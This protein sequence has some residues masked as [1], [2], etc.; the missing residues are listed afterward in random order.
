MPDGSSSDAPVTTPG[1]KDLRVLTIDER[2]EAL[3]SDGSVC[4]PLSP[5][6]PLARPF[7]FNII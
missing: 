5:F 1:P 3:V 4:D 7:F 6:S 2:G